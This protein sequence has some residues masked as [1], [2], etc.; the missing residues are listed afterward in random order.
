MDQKKKIRL[1]LAILP[2]MQSEVIYRASVRADNK[3]ELVPSRLPNR[4]F[5]SDLLEED[6]E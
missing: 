1:V 6:E 5:T 2:V 3:G 4:A